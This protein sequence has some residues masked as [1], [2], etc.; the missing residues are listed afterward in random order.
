MN[1]EI[2]GKPIKVNVWLSKFAFSYEHGW[3]LSGEISFDSG[4]IQDLDITPFWDP[5]VL[6]GTM[7]FG[8]DVWDW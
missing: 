6:L 4:F 1:I 5:S 8:L 3:C 2:P 7:R